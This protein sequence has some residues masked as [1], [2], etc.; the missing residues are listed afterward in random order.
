M[1]NG[2]VPV[3]PPDTWP[4]YTITAFLGL[5][6]GIMGTHATHGEKIARV[7]GEV[8]A[9]KAETFSIKNQLDRMEKALRE[10]HK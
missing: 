6:V 9:I 3:P 4:K 10:Q 1:A 5:L 7:E 2:Q 8:I